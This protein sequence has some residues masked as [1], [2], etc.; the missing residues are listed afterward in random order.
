M[1]GMNENKRSNMRDNKY[2]VNTLFSPDV[3]AKVNLSG[4]HLKK[5]ACPRESTI[6]G[7]CIYSK[8][9]GI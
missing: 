5:Q 2:F 4:M 3:S 1:Q 6:R 8:H 9:S 7:L